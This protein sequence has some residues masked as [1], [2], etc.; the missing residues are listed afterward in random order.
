MTD[1]VFVNVDELLRENKRLFAEKQRATDYIAESGIG[2]GDDPIG[3]L[4]AAHASVITEVSRKNWALKAI[5]AN[6][7]KRDFIKRVC[8]QALEERASED[9][10]LADTVKERIADPKIVDVNLEDLVSTEQTDVCPNTATEKDCTQI[11]NTQEP[12]VNVCPGCGGYLGPIPPFGSWVWVLC[13]YCGTR[14][15][16]PEKT[17]VEKGQT[18][19]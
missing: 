4:M 6:Y 3:F 13:T 9:Q 16:N 17:L 11:G 2:G 10:A 8:S 18:H 5:Q 7:T 19:E 12:D 1:E 14:I 15:Y